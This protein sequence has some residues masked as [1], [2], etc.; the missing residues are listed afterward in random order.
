[1]NSNDS[2]DALI[3]KTQAIDLR[4]LGEAALPGPL[5]LKALHS[6]SSVA[7]ESEEKGGDE[8]SRYLLHL[9][10]TTF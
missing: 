1:M 2:I 10:S 8:V 3:S 9:L 4:D 7:D 5:M 6:G